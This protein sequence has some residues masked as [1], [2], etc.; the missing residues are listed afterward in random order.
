M[1]PVVPLLFTVALLFQGIPCRANDELEKA[2]AY[3]NE[4]IALFDSG[5]F[6]QAAEKFREANQVMYNWKLLY[7]IGQ[8]EAAARHHGLALETFEEYISRG[9]DEIPMARR[10]EVR[11]E[12]RRLREMVGYLDIEG[13]SGSQLFVNDM[14]RGSLPLSG[15]IA[16]ATG[17]SHRIVL[18][19]ED[20]VIFE[21]EIRIPGTQTIKISAQ[22]ATPTPAQ[23]GPAATDASAK[24]TSDD[25]K[26]PEVVPRR[27][28]SPPTDEVA[29]ESNL[30]VDI[31]SN[32]GPTQSSL[33]ESSRRLRTLGIIGTGI[34]AACLIT[35]GITGAIAMSKANDLEDRYGSVVPHSEKSDYDT[36][37]HTA[38]ISTV[39]FISGGVI[40]AAG[41]ALLMISKKKKEKIT[42]LTPVVGRNA[43]G[44]LLGGKF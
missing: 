16:V 2:T 38:T 22:E 4:G 34:G 32:N 3:F 7:N 6:P 17:V 14:S 18:L 21:K 5:K 24:M 23:T 40:S 12:I 11:S 25:V 37:Q 20:N 36:T 9:G 35:G 30:T 41:I 28:D 31:G 42:T 27:S 19:K 1:K 44:I 8:C 15:P 29:E 43:A 33:S 10:E 39:M 26:G 13:P